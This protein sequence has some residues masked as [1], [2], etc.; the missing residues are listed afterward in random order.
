MSDIIIML[1]VT[2]IVQR[3]VCEKIIEIAINNLEREAEFSI[4]H[5]D[6]IRFC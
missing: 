3:L 6:V 1:L 5:E 2:L 4:I